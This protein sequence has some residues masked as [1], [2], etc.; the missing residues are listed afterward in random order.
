VT[1]VA[2]V[3][4]RGETLGGKEI[5]SGEFVFPIDVCYGCLIVYNDVTGFC[6]VRK[7]GETIPVQCQSGQDEGLDCRACNTGDP[8][9]YA[10][11]G[12]TCP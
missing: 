1:V 8:L 6:C 3:K 12:H 2:S 7:E 5:E 4:V 9:C 10:A 11:Q